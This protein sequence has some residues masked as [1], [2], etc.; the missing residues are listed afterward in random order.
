MKK[1]N[2]FY[3]YLLK[4]HHTSLLSKKDLHD[5]K[6]LIIQ[7]APTTRCKLDYNGKTWTF[8]EHHISVYADIEEDVGY[9]SLYHY[10]A[11]CDHDKLH[12]YFNKRNEPIAVTLTE[13]D[14]QQT[15]TLT[16]L[17]KD[18]ATELLPIKFVI[19][20]QIQPIIQPLRA[21]QLAEINTL[22]TEYTKKLDDI[23]TGLFDDS[24]N[25]EANLRC[26]RRATNLGNRLLL[27]SYKKK[28]LDTTLRYLHQCEKTLSQA[29]S[30]SAKSRSKQTTPLASLAFTESKTSGATVASKRTVPKQPRT[31]KMRASAI[32][33]LDTTAILSIT[34]SFENTY[35][36][37]LTMWGTFEACAE[38]SH[39]LELFKQLGQYLPAL[40]AA[41]LELLSELEAPST[42]AEKILVHK[43][44]L[45][46]NL[47]QEAYTKAGVNLLLQC[48]QP[49]GVT[50]LEPYEEMLEKFADL[51]PSTQIESAIRQQNLPAL[52]FLLKHTKISINYYL[53][54]DKNGI[55]LSPL[56]AAYKY[57]NVGMFELLLK[58]NASCMAS[59]QG[60]P[61]AHTLLQLGA[62]DQFQQLFLNHYEPALNGN[63]RFYKT[64]AAAVARKLEEGPF[65]SALHHAQAAYERVFQANQGEHIKLSQSARSNIVAIRNAMNPDMIEQM[66]VLS[67]AERRLYAELEAKSLEL[68]TLMSKTHQT[69][70]LMRTSEKQLK[71]SKKMIDHKLGQLFYAIT[72]EEVLQEI[73]KQI[74][75]LNA[76]ITYCTLYPKKDHLSKSEKRDFIAAAQTLQQAI[77]T[78]ADFA[79]LLEELDTARTLPQPNIN[80]LTQKLRNMGEIGEEFMA[81]R[82]LL[83]PIAR[84]RPALTTAMDNL[85]E[86]TRQLRDLT[87]LTDTSANQSRF[88]RSACNS[89]TQPAVRDN[90]QRVGTQTAICDEDSDSEFEGLDFLEASEAPSDPMPIAAQ[91]GSPT[92]D[93]P[94]ADEDGFFRRFPFVL[95]N[96][97]GD[98]TEDL[99]QALIVYGSL[100]CRI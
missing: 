43:A 54:K 25:V 13:H 86:L 24:E 92:R 18:T 78:Q 45:G 22:Q 87:T 4:Q 100:P 53:I 62:R 61:L 30:A 19:E 70:Q 46:I 90:I 11:T 31:E 93:T 88:F 49:T 17:L 20:Q 14:S 73:Q 47:V 28:F 58:H 83:E 29:Q 99:S 69:T 51:L 85:E 32:K 79:H 27:I 82:N 15:T 3:Q 64:L 26:I 2:P 44:D 5:N 76:N 66:R 71:N 96:P 37:Y 81:L 95:S 59:Y 48:L 40:H 42:A 6:Y 57:G 39:K 33:L 9:E 98:P 8:T 50:A 75:L 97:P 91:P 52:A 65:D 74:D 68:C 16:H 41:G 34:T 36:H 84:S 10:T 60:L 63:P 94:L 56:C 67:P 1:S 23:E 55:W 12:I 72:K 21:Q 77:K 80:D 7:L 35:N 38:L 89:S